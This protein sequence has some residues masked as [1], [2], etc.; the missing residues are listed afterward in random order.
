MGGGGQRHAHACFSENNKQHKHNINKY[1]NNNRV[2]IFHVGGRGAGPLPSEVSGLRSGL[3]R[4]G[5]QG[6]YLQAHAVHRPDLRNLEVDLWS[7]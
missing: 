4:R 1:T 2:Y 5:G 3:V 7:H 6:L